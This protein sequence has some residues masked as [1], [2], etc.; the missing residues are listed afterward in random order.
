M[1]AATD[2]AA[3]Q[4]RMVLL[5]PA[6]LLAGGTAGCLMITDMKTGNGFAVTFTEKDRGS[7]EMALFAFLCHVP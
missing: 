7:R 6:A 5:G 4:F 1:A 3:D 2:Q